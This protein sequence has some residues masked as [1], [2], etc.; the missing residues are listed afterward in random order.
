MSREIVQT[1][2]TER[3]DGWT[4]YTVIARDT[5]TGESHSETTSWFLDSDR[6]DRVDDANER[7][8]ND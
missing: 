3:N 5:E 2:E 1:I 4:D 8:L 6:V 7:V